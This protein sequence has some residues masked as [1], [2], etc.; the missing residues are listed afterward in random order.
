M[1]T[2]GQRCVPWIAVFALAAGPIGVLLAAGKPVVLKPPTFDQATTEL[3]ATDA[4][5]KIG[6]GEPGARRPAGAAPGAPTEGDGEGAMAGGG[7]AWSKLIAPENLEA[8]V[9]A[10]VPITAEAVKTINIFKGNGREKAQTAFNELT[11]LF[12]V[13]AQYDG[14]VRWKKEAAGLEK[15]YAQVTANCKTSSDAAYKEAQLRSTALAELVR[16]GTV[17]VPKGG[18]ASLAWNEVLNRPALMRRMEE[19]RSPGSTVTKGISN[20]GDFKKNKDALLREVQLL[21]TISEVIKAK[22]FDSADDEGYQGYAKTFQE[23]CGALLEAIK[24]DSQDKAQS[25]FAQINKAC[26]TCHG[27]FR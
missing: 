11:M 18:D 1:R 13:I 12:G 22:G 19:M 14:E 27:D 21:A 8:E 7:F 15:A 6:P 23:Q 9:K 25:A 2:T 16:G 4:R 26:D 3:F 24:A 17:E 5:T 20:K 10:M